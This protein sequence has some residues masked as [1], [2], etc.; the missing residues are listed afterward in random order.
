MEKMNKTLSELF[1][2]IMENEKL[3]QESVVSR[4]TT[5]KDK[6][7]LRL[8]VTFPGII[9]KRRIYRIEYLIKNQYF[10]GAD[11]SVK[12]IEKFNL[13]DNYTLEAIYDEYKDS[14]I[15]ELNNTDKILYTIYQNSKLKFNDNKITV[16]IKDDGLTNFYGENLIRFFDKI[17]NNRCNFNAKIECSLVPV[18]E[19]ALKEKKEALDNEIK[20]ISK[21]IVINSEANEEEQGENK[22]NN[23]VSKDKL[24]K[25]ESN[26]IYGRYVNKDDDITS[27]IDADIEDDYITIKGQVIDVSETPIK[28]EKTIVIFSIYDKTDTINC[29]IFIS[30]SKLDNLNSKLY[31]NQFVKVTGKPEEDKFDNELCMLHIRSIVIIE[32]FFEKRIDKSPEKRVELHCK[33]KMSDMD[34]VSSVEDIMKAANAFG[35]KALA[36]TDTGSVQ[37][38][39]LADHFRSEVLNLKIIYGLDAYMVDD[40]RKIVTNPKDQTFESKFVVFDIETTGFN[41]TKDYIIEIGAVK[42]ENGE[43]T[44]RFSEFI[45]PTVPIPYNITELTS[46]TNDMVKD[47]P[48]VD[49]ILPA[50]LKFSEGC[51]MVA[52]NAEFDMSFIK[53]K[54]KMLNLSYPKTYM[55][56][57][58]MA[59]YLLPNLSNYKLE[60]VAKELGVSL[61]DHHRA[62][63]DAECTAHIF[64][65]LAAGFKEKG[66]NK[67]SDIECNIALSDT[68]IRKLHQYNCTIL[69]KNDIGRINL[70]RLV[71]LSHL[72]YYRMV[73]K[74]P[75][76]LIRKYREGLIIGSGTSKGELYEAVL[77]GRPEDKLVRIASFYD[78]L[79]MQPTENNKSLL[80]NEKSAAKNEEDLRNINRTIYKLAKKINKIPVATSDAHF[81]NPEDEIY[82][83]IIRYGNKVKNADEEAPLYFRTTDEMLK[84]FSYMGS[85]IAKEVVI[86]NTNKIA[87]MCE[88]ISPTRPDKCP[89]SILNADKILRTICENK[90]HEMY[91]DNLPEIVVKR[92]EK[93]LNS[94][95]K[96][97][98]AVMYIIAQKLVW[99]SN[100]DG[101]LV[102]SRGSVGS[103][104]VAT[105][106]GITEVNPLP[107]HYLCKKCH[108]SD[109]DSKMVKSFAGRSGTDMPD[110]KCPNCGCDL[111]KEG[112]DIPFETFLGFKGNKEPDIDLN[113]SG[114]YQAK[115]H[116]Y[117]EVIFGEG[118][119]YK[120]GT[121]GTVAEKTAYGYVK[122]YFEEHK[123]LKRNSEINRIVKHCT[124]IKRT[125]GQHPGGIIVLPLGEE[126]NTFTPVQHPADDMKSDLITTH[127]DYHSIDKNLLKLDILGH[128]DPTMMK[129]LSDLTGI[130]V[131]KI[132]LDD[133]KIMS[134][135]MDTSALNLHGKLKSADLGTLGIPEFGTNFAMGLL[136]DAKPKEFSDLIRVSGLS[137]GTN[138][139]QGNAEVL[140]KNKTATISSA[141]CC[142]DDIMVYLINMGLDKEESFTIMERVR[143]GI[144]A[145][146]K[147]EEWE[148][149]KK[150]MKEHNVPDWYIWSCE[151]IK[152]MFPKAHAAAYVMMAWRI[153]YFKIY[154]PLAYYA[155]YFSIR[156]KA[157]NYELMCMGKD[158]LENAMQKYELIEQKEKRQLTSVEKNAYEDMKIV[159]EMYL[160]GFGFL[161]IDIYSSDAKYFKIVG[162]KLLPP[163]NI[164]PNL[165][166]KAALSLNIA[167]RDGKFLSKEDLKERGKITKN[168][169]YDMER[170]GIIKYL[171]ESNQISI[172]DLI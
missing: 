143:K 54:S 149:Y 40:E 48:K 89:P 142:R 119:T 51:V 77:N 163:F 92:M 2:S 138:V 10:K 39:N 109:F 161:P 128:D 16:E 153:A 64:E 134:L 124:D 171:P 127:F 30:N 101:Y 6:S 80:L 22:E 5:S 26:I 75:K 20:E 88:V 37:S 50:F 158:A 29:K 84:E 144:V 116:R 12:I 148:K 24:P 172:F 23:I 78:F 52:H 107:A 147:C 94:I 4:V 123:V 38:F 141:I 154:Y 102:G 140:I 49:I 135:F 76:S 9:Q 98:Y 162:D 96:N 115:A 15:E 159:E 137:H 82:R 13:S 72:K 113:F 31:S 87:D 3:F 117:V 79:E 97:G 44:D 28:N 151:Q 103:S 112:F 73:P 121:I 18:D 100:E 69:A 56:S 129:M 65:K 146:G 156:A 17:F 68:N 67:L 14:I 62:V 93:E 7:I 81:L 164:I 167:A 91:G 71:S 90:A 105:L 95:I 86:D 32:D 168:N 11:V 59:R 136:K 150:D 166:D 130:D 108:Y 170:L 165:G 139:W 85:S 120:A 157:F 35:H 99:K 42:F 114:D 160:R 55:D 21:N 27:I 58:E 132:P 33:T 57:V 47:A 104:F 41:S 106:S 34:G 53:E 133:K 1:P 70:Y 8:Y 152:Y 169:I 122:K 61:V 131:T 125:T 83:R 126:I 110:M 46:I 118:Q 155:A 111:S 25:L 63:N 45:N 60:K 74:I 36:I 19:E 145:K 66:I 43:I